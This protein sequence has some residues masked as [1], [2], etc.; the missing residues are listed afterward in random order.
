MCL[1]VLA[2]KTHPDYPLILL[3]NR[4]ESYS[5]ATK[6][7][8]AWNTQPA[9]YAGQDLEAGGTWLGSTPNGRFAALTNLRQ[10]VTAPATRSRGELVREFLLSRQT[11]TDYLDRV[12]LQA[13]AY[14]P[15]NLLVANTRSLMYFSHP[16]ENGRLLPAGIYALSN[17]PLGQNWPKTEE[18]KVAFTRLISRRDPDTEALLEMMRQTQVYPAD[19]LPDTG[20]PLAQEQALSSIFIQLPDYGT[21]STSL[22]TWHRQG[23]ARLLE[24]SYSSPTQWQDHCEI[25][26]LKP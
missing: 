9:I 1:I 23:E 10:P 25:F 3:A 13:K 18:S 5:R 26:D 6:S 8:H 22:L 16:A 19:L 4:D 7:L 2:W 15:F 14:A 11:P 24:R 21:R 20:L 17:A 12:R